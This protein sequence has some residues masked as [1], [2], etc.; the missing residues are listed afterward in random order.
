MAT[1][2]YVK[3]EYYS[4]GVPPY[5][6]SGFFPELLDDEKMTIETPNIEMSYHQYFGLFKRFMMSVGFSEKNII[7]GACN[8]AFNESNDKHLMEEV[9]KEYDLIMCE[10]ISKEVENRL[11]EERKFYKK[12]IEDEKQRTLIWE[13]RYNTLFNK[14][15]REDNARIWDGIIPGTPQAKERGCICPVLDNEEMP[16]D[17]KWVNMSCPIHGRNEN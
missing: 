11:E 13:T 1:E 15:K 10:N 8:L 16:D 14:L 9:A 5:Y 3:F 17:K 12:T 2:G 7:Q 6:N 4:K